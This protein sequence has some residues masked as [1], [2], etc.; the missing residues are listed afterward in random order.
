MHGSN[1][2]RAI[3]SQA[4]G[5][6]I[7]GIGGKKM[8]DAGV[9]IIVPASDMA[10][11]GLIEI[12]TRLHTI[13]QAHRKLKNLLKHNR[14]DLLILIDYPGFNLN[15]AR[16]AKRYGVPVLYYISPQVWAWRRG[17]IK[18]IARRVDRMVVILPFEKAYY[19]NSGVDVNYVG[20][21]LLDA[22]PQD[23]DRK[24]VIKNL[25]LK[26]DHPIIGLLPGS[27]TEEIQTLLPLMI[28]G[29]QLLSVHYPNIQ[30][31]LPLASTIPVNRV[32]SEIQK[33][34][35]TINV[36]R[37]DIYSTL[38]V[39]DLA[40]VASG[41]ATL[42]TA[43]MEV[44]MVIVYRV[45]SL[46][47][48]IGKRIVKV[49]YIGLANLIAGE[50]IVPELLQDEVTP[51]RIAEEARK[52][53]GDTQIREYIIGQLRNIKKSLGTGG[54]SEK[55]ARIALEMMTHKIIVRTL[56]WLELYL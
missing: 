41:T 55:A 21:P 2:V 35:I 47:F 18:K 5:T 13:I 32:E 23:I 27:R 7:T 19:K 9:E 12:F 10:V 22:I 49:P 14:P 1:L 30:C 44:P 46:S 43:M 56:K 31:V 38:S 17:R 8:K 54:A 26:N 48:L 50:R 24:M 33:S 42:E 53:L 52:I 25:G 20:H 45:S 51:S 3:I 39:C 15:L 6:Q 29:I 16:I 37:E 11:V 4:P 34:S 40:L 36:S 28:Q